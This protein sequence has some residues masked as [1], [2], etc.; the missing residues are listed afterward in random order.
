MISVPC[1]DL[2]Q[3]LKIPPDTDALSAALLHLLG[4]S[5]ALQWSFECSLA[6]PH[7]TGTVIL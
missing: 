5:A 2:S 7:A 3:T 4:G 6:A 1:L